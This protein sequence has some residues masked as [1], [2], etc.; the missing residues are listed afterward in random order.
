MGNKIIAIVD[1]GQQRKEKNISYRDYPMMNYITGR[2]LKN[3]FSYYYDTW[4]Q[5]Q[6]EI[7]NYL[8]TM[9]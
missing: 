5:Y 9:Y 8:N 4:E 3:W 6:E 2:K 7:K 1:I